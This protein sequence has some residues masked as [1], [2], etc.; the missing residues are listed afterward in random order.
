MIAQ[1]H[2][3]DNMFRLLIMTV[4]FDILVAVLEPLCLLLPGVGLLI[5]RID[6]ED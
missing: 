6:L 4:S 2:S 1:L 3:F 5:V